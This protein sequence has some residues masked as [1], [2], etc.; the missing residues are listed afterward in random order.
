MLIGYVVDFEVMSKVCRHFSVAKN[1]L[2][3][4]RAEFSIWYKEQKSEC[5]I[6]HL[7]SSTSM[8]M[9]A[10]FTLWKNPLHSDFITSQFYRMVIVKRSATRV[11]KKVYG[12]DIVIK[13]EEYINHVSKWL[14]TALKS[15]VKDRRT[16][17]ISLG[18]KCH[19]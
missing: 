13:K 8:E 11:R 19:G 1:K 9:E 14:G 3:E 5:D 4:S 2:G 15:T 10:A 12:P 7:N 16:Q 18:G 6:N 17:S